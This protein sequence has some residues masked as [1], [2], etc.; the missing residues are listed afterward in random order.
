MESVITRHVV[1]QSI[2]ADR[3]FA[4]AARFA[5]ITE[6]ECG[7]TIVAYHIGCRKPSDQYLIRLM[8]YAATQS[9][10]TVARRLAAT[11]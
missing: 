4:T 6:A 3:R 2:H 10:I 7:I 11:V 5:A 8:R 1:M 9:C